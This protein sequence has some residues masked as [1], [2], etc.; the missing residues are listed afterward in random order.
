MPKKIEDVRFVK[1]KHGQW[2]KETDMVTE[3]Q[4]LDRRRPAPGWRGGA[5]VRK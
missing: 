3:D 2:R 1:G 4:W 5:R